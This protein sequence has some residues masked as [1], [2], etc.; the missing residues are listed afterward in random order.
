MNNEII[1]IL[2]NVA[3]LKGIVCVDNLKHEIAYEDKHINDYLAV[4]VL[5]E[6]FELGKAEVVFKTDKE[7]KR[8]KYLLKLLKESEGE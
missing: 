3:Q 2:K 4:G 1:K 8:M 6:L 7:D 5:A